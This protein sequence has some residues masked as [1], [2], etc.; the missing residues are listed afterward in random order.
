[1]FST[2][3]NTNYY[4]GEILSLITHTLESSPSMDRGGEYIWIVGVQRVVYCNLNENDFRGSL[5]VHEAG[6]FKDQLD[7]YGILI[8]ENGDYVFSEERKQELVSFLNRYK[9]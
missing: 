1:M 9:G 4:G 3:H 8:R 5:E 6:Q 7:F 2:Y